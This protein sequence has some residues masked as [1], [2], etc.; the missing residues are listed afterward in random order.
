MRMVT[1][2]GSRHLGRVSNLLKRVP[3][4]VLTNHFV[5]EFNGFREAD[6]PSG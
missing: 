6:C 5:M 4:N 2:E 3:A 1:Q